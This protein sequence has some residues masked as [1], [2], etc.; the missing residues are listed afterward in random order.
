MTP[1]TTTLRRTGFGVVL[2]ALCCFGANAAFAM[3]PDAPRQVLL[4]LRAPA[5][6]A[7]P[8]AGY[9][10]D[11][12][13]APGHAARARIARRLAEANGLSLRS[14]WPMPALGLECYVLEA[15]DA[16]AV[17]RAV[18]ALAKDARVE[19]VQAM[20]DFEVLGG[21]AE[22]DPLYPAQPAGAAW[23]LDELHTVTTG[24]GVTV[25]VIDSGIADAHPDLRGQI[26]L[27]RDFVDDNN[28]ARIVP[29]RHG[30]EVA[31]L[32]A[33]RAGNQLGIAGVAPDAKLLALRACWQSDGTQ[34]ARCNSFTL[35]KALQFAIDRRAQVI[36]MSLGGPRDVLLTRLLDVAMQRGA[37][38]VAA[39]DPK[40]PD[41]GFPASVPGVV[42]VAGDTSRALPFRAYLAPAEGL[43]TTLVDGGWGLVDGTS[44]A[45]AEVSGLVAL[46]RQV[47]PRASPARLRDALGAGPALGSATARPLPIDACAALERAG[48][49][50]ACGCRLAD[51]RETPRH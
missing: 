31:G 45:T 4:M 2:F 11:Y 39:V 44:F 36:N 19:S 23:K 32:I 37:I 24:R 47:A 13:Q 42:A 43:P 10:D 8:D 48:P 26:A 49:G 50:C 20:Q 15:T 5:V 9:V 18:E 6:H 46:L 21:D 12:T 29:E 41:G 7:R 34:R 17:P 27:H 16:N 22:G 14:V 28:T 25:A 35:A 3:Q 51:S 40:A 30:T 38:I 33:A 1:R